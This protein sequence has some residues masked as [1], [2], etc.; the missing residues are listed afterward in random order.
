[1]EALQTNTATAEESCVRLLGQAAA[2]GAEF[3][4]TSFC[5]CLI[6]I[7]LCGQAMSQLRHNDNFRNLPGIRVIQHLN[8]AVAQL[9]THLL[10]MLRS[11]FI[12]VLPQDLITV[13]DLPGP[14]CS[15][16]L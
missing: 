16:A 10:P 15:D 3:A 4:P 14:Q 6:S 5:L 12:E 2:K 1:M 9:L 8:H 7:L 11:F 13:M